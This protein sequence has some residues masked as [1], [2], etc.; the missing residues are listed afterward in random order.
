MRSRDIKSLRKTFGLGQRQ[1]GRALSLASSGTVALLEQGRRQTPVY[2]TVVL[3]R[4]RQMAAKKRTRE[5][6]RQALIDASSMPARHRQWRHC[7]LGHLT[8]TIF[9][10]DNDD[11]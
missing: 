10:D 7:A 11:N 9:K 1:L 8:E 5:L 4:L 6:A 2:V 3:G